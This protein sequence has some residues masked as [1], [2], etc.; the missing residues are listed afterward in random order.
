MRE[1]V[2]ADLVPVDRTAALAFFGNF[3]VYYRD[4]SGAIVSRTWW[5]EVEGKSHQFP[6]SGEYWVK[7][8]TAERKRW[9]P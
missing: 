2:S 9:Q 8:T 5:C 3:A 7:K 6:E 1:E 4:E